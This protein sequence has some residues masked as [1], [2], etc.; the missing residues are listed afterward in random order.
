MKHLEVYLMVNLM[1]NYNNLKEYWEFIKPTHQKSYV[2]IR[3][4]P[5]FNDWQDKKQFYTHTYHLIQNGIKTT[6]PFQFF[7]NSYD[8]LEKIAKIGNEWLFNNVK[9]CYGLNERFEHDNKLGGTYDNLK[10]TR[11]VFLDIDKKDHS[12]I[13]EKEE[14]LLDNYILHVK[15][16]LEYYKL[17]NPTIVKS[18]AGVHLI[19]KIIPQST[20]NGHRLWYK[21]WCDNLKNILVHNKFEIDMVSDFTR[22]FGLPESMNV[23]R[24]IKVHYTNINNDINGDFKFRVKKEP[25]IKIDAINEE[26]LPE[27]KDS[28][29]WKIITHPE[30]PQGEV[31]SILL[32]ALKLLIKA[33]GVKDYK[34]YEKELNAVRKT[35]HRLQ[36]TNGTKGKNYNKGIIINWMKRNEEWCKKQNIYILP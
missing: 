4:I 13:E 36:P 31:H 7:I 27:I 5:K 10:E 3:F 19:Y 17:Y 24:K 21:Y 28:L 26:D 22:V 1:I 16:Q 23:K 33:K 2:E 25:K 20:S 18:G 9:V 32:F 14:W 35:N 11:F 34:I 12:M 15:K 6:T 29:E 8:E 30:V